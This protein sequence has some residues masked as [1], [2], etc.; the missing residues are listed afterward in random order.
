MY[1]TEVEKWLD[2]VAERDER[3]YELYG[4]PHEYVHEGEYIAIGSDGRT[5]ISTDPDYVLIRAVETF[6]RGNF[7]L[8]RIGHKA[9]GQWLTL[10]P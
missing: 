1:S 10:S 9:F 8:T 7:A 6:G 4:K 3:L 2:E 5:I